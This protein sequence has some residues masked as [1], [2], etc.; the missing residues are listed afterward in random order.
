MAARSA[1]SQMS[2]MLQQREA[3]IPAGLTEPARAAAPA[4]GL[5]EILDGSGA[6]GGGAKG[7]DIGSGSDGA[8][9]FDD[10]YAHVSL[11]RDK[12]AAPGQVVRNQVARCWRAQ[13]GLPGVILH[14]Q[15][16][17]SGALRGD[18]KA[19]GAATDP[20]SA[21]AVARARQALKAC[22]PYPIVT[23]D[24]QTLSFDLKF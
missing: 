5:S 3:D 20:A 16:E 24:P 4:T 2:Q 17:A 19:V 13:P 9:G 18:P 11:Y 14:V 6:A 1:A 15:L 12:A 7:Q 22:A 8:F 21:E 23:R 10:P